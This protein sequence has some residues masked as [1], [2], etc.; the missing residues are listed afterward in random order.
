MELVYKTGYGVRGGRLIHIS[1]ATRGLAC[2]CV[3]VACGFL[4][5][6]K[7]GSQRRHHFAHAVDADCQG[8]AETALHLLSKELF[9]E[10]KFIILPPYKF[11]KERKTKTGI[12]VNHQQKIAKGGDVTIKGVKIE[13]RE[14][15]FFPDVILDCGTKSLIVEIAVTHK[16]DRSKMRHIRRRDLPTIE[17]RLDYS[18]ALLSREELRNKLQNDLRSKFWLFHPS[19]REAERAFFLKFRQTTNAERITKTAF[20]ASSSRPRLSTAGSYLPS[21][22]NL[23]EYEKKAEEFYKQHKRY[24]NMEECLRLWPRLWRKS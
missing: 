15:G 18:D 7:K 9:E 23:N 5:V 14:V 8:A 11:V 19:Q 6:A 4:L 10:L 1:E 20:A 13:S 17:I 24:P 2:E 12:P 16:V 22:S 21:T 3:C